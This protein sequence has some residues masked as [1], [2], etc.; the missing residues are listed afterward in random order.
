MNAATVGPALSPWAPT[1]AAILGGDPGDRRHVA[2]L[3]ATGGFAPYAQDDL[4]APLGAKPDTLVVL[5]GRAKAPERIRDLRTVAEAN[6][7]AR[8]VAAMPTDAP[9]ASLR[10]AL[11]AGAAGLVLDADL[12]RALVATSH[13]VLAGQLAVP[14]ALVRQIAPR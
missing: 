7:K 14:S 5:L 2:E 6:A 9:N 13:A 12:D 11:L 3:L 8:I 1:V 4:H 10:R